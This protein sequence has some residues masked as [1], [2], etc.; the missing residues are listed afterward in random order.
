MVQFISDKV[1][2]RIYG[3]GRGWSFSQI[4]FSD[5]ASRENVDTI[6]HRLEKRSTIRR[7]LPGIYDYPKMSAL[8]NEKLPPDI[9]QVAQ[10]LARKFGWTIVPSGETALNILGITNQIPA[11]YV[12]SSN[13]RSKTYQIGNR[14]L[15]FKKGM[16]RESNFKHDE[17]AIL[18]QAI[19]AIGQGKITPDILNQLKDSVPAG[20]KKQILR[21]TRSVTGWVYEVIQ[22]ISQEVE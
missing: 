2:A 17:S 22:K 1:I 13:G 19:R 3:K 11:R 21:D 6:L 7:L 14:E 15:E 5:L 8:V 4:D 12:Y 10:A 18:V 16:L 20:K 9:P